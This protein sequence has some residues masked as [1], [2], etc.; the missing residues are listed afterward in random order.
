M[1]GVEALVRWKQGADVVSPGK[2]IPIAEE[3]GLIVPL[4]RWVLQE[5]TRQCAEFN[6]RS[7]EPLRVCVNVSALQ[8]QRPNFANDVSQLLREAGLSP[9]QL[10]VEL[11]ESA[12]MQNPE[13]GS[14]GMEQLQPR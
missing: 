13:Q 3:C 12:L 10:V 2:F 5:A 9:K 7:R 11:T 1:R 6:R 8:I 4:G 14:Y